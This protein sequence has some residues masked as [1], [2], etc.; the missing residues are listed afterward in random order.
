MIQSKLGK[1]EQNIICSEEGASSI[2]LWRY[3]EILTL[4]NR[5]YVYMYPSSQAQDGPFIFFPIFFFFIYLFVCF[6]SMAE[7]I[8]VPT[9]C[10]LPNAIHQSLKVEGHCSICRYVNERDFGL[11][12]IYINHI[13]RQY[14][15]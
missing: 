4:S 9:C 13:Q 11:F 7:G 1:G 15:C 6:I 5:T 12:F 3:V 10:M 14:Y 8:E 2:T